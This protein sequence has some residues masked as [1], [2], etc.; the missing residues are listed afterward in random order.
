MRRS[1]IIIL[2]LI[3]I[4]SSTICYLWWFY[5][6]SRQE[7]VRYEIEEGSTLR[8]I[9]EDLKALDVIPS[10]FS[11]IICAKIFRFEKTLKQGVYVFKPNMS[12]Y[13]VLKELSKGA[14]EYV[15][16]TFP[17]GLNI[18]QI[19]SKLAY[20]FKHIPTQEWLHAMRNT[21]LLSELN[22]DFGTT[23]PSLEG[24]LFPQTYNFLFNATKYDV[25][26]MMLYEFK[27]HFTIS[28]V[29]KGR[30]L[31]LTPYQIVVM[32]SMVEKE[33]VLSTEQPQIASVF[34]N[35][36]KEQMKFQSDPTVIYGMW[37]R[38]KGNITKKDL[39]TP[40]PYNTYTNPSFPIG[41]IANPGE[42]AL[43]AV[44]HPL[45]THDL[46]F[47]A[48]GDGT[49]YFSSSLPEHNRAIRYYIFGNKSVQPFKKITKEIKV[50]KKTPAKKN[51]K[52]QTKQQKKL[53]NTSY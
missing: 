31:G 19:S 28:L 49:H 25:I 43:H 14:M 39:L 53:K 15:K 5:A 41:P 2:T 44:T 18:W 50:E 52:Q 34:F 23:P 26:R 37:T 36:I 42:T 7:S 45:E 17:E 8:D 12:T 10:P 29:E 16:I 27:R 32:A 46:Y 13:Q 1:L 51:A 21:N 35:R 40:T 38:Y 20:Y 11:F 48:K 24:F 47:V 4:S 3:F 30:K 33:S 6:P 22:I 9:A